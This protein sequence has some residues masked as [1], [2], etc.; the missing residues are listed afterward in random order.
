M[1]CTDRVP[2][3]G[4]V[5]SIYIYTHSNLGSSIAWRFMPPGSP[6][7]GIIGVSLPVQAREV[8]DRTNFQLLESPCFRLCMLVLVVKYP[9]ERVWRVL[10]F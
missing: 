8:S 10:R 5:I 2:I 4:N 7:P 1:I 9:T 3:E 6:L